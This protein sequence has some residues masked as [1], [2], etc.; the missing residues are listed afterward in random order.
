LFVPCFGGVQKWSIFDVFS[1]FGVF[2]WR[3]LSEAFFEG[4]QTPFWNDF[5]IENG[6]RIEE[7][8]MGKI[9][10]KRCREEGKSMP[11]MCGK[12]RSTVPPQ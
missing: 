10:Q 2:F 6:A 11:G 5:G 4:L 12:A 1:N 3:C 8:T 9:A 7:K